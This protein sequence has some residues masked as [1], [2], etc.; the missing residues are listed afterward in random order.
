MERADQNSGE[1]DALMVSDLIAD[2]VL[3][4]IDGCHS[5]E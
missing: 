4:P 1:G 2:W 5:P 3:G